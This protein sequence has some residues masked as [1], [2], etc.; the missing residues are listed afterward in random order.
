MGE[1]KASIITGIRNRSNHFSLTFPFNISQVG[2]NYELIY[3]NFNSTDDCF[4]S[5]LLEHIRKY[6]DIFSSNLLSIKEIYVKDDDYYNPS[7]ANNLGEC[8]S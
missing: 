4:S 6:E 8:F 3:V 7:E 5:L 1:I 2:T